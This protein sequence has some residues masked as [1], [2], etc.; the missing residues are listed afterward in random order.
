M[1]IMVLSESKPACFSRLPRKEFW[2]TGFGL[3]VGL[4]LIY[5]TMTFQVKIRDSMKGFFD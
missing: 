1:E 2:L 3:S 5:L 4:W